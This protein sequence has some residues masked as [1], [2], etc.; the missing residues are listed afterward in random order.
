METDI[1]NPSSFD[2]PTWG[3][4]P[5]KVEICLGALLI[6]LGTL[7]VYI[8]ALP[9]DVLWDDDLYVSNN[10]LLFVEDG[11][12]RIWACPTESP[13]YYPMVFTSFWLESRLVG[14]STFGLHLVNTGL[15]GL[16]AVL[17]WM[18]LSRLQVRGA[19]L[20]GLLFAL[21]PVHVES[22]AWITERKN[23][24]SALFFLL[25]VGV[26]LRC[27]E[28]RS[29]L[30]YALSLALFVC[31]LLSK[32]A[33]CFL[34]V[35]LLLLAWWKR[36]RIWHREALALLPFFLVGLAFGL[37][38]VLLE[39]HQVGAVGEEWAL[40]WLERGLLANRALWFYVGNLFWPTNL[41]FNYP[42]WE[43]DATAPWQ[44]A[45]V[46][47]TVAVAAGL[48]RFR[49]RLGRGP[50][51][52]LGC[53]VAGI[54][55]VLGFFNVYYFRYAYVAD[56]FQYHADMGIIALVAVLVVLALERI[57]GLRSPSRAWLRHVALVLPLVC[58]VLSFRQAHLYTDIETLWR[59]TIARNPNSWLAHY[60]LALMLLPGHE[61]DPQVCAEAREH[62]E[63]VLKIN[64][65]CSDAHVGLGIIAGAGGDHKGAL[66][67]YAK[68]ATIDPRNTRAHYHAGKEFYHG[69]EVER[70]ETA[71][72]ACL[73]IAPRH[74]RAHNSLG[75]ILLERGDRR[76]ATEHFQLALASNP[77]NAAALY[78]L[79]MAYEGA[80]RH[81]DAIRLYQRALDVAPRMANAGFRMAVCLRETGDW[82]AAEA[83]Y[84]KTLEMDPAYGDAWADLAVMEYEQGR[85]S[86]AVG[87]YRRALALQPHNLKV[88]LNLVSAYQ[89]LN[90]Y[91]EAIALVEEGLQSQPEDLA[92]MHQQARLLATAPDATLRDPERAVRLAQ[93]VVEHL[94][95]LRP[96]AL[97]TLAR[98]YAETGAY[99]QAIESARRGLEL[100]HTLGL[101][102]LEKQLTDQL[103]EYQTRRNDPPEPPLGA[104]QKTPCCLVALLPRCQLPLARQE[105]RRAALVTVAL[106]LQACKAL[107]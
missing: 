104:R 107:L 21:H 18:V 37:A 71:F 78:H 31:A 20:A 98:A 62:L 7:V 101:V 79:G 59:Q 29:W 102:E 91:G 43:I 3:G 44:Y 9:G 50:L 27:W 94:D 46:G 65:R 61:D 95:P 86:E 90:R 97:R 40:S 30:L 48:W 56:H 23:V 103:L 6:I 11:L 70:A 13:Q 57:A 93:E 106:G 26:Y 2:C 42:R 55:P 64:P 81:R 25:S 52:A 12:W 83:A 41:T 88:R 96:E 74:S 22:V 85:V 8:P 100:A 36:R 33:T 87:S 63:T 35:V 53:F 24:L 51:V 4:A 76:R 89:R 99:G 5:R 66:E 10:P 72:R 54:A 58:G 45:F 1:A 92:L 16:S 75:R 105:S 32:T 77:R 14:L 67:Q 39:K 28:R 19:W 17:L 15:H 84:R 69:G 47:L 34:P 82:E 73:K 38:T 68:A 60:N 80:G 49:G